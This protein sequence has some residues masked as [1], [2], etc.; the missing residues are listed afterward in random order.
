[1]KVDLKD[2]VW[3]CSVGGI[4]VYSPTGKVIGFIP[5]VEPTNMAFGGSGKQTTLYITA[6]DK[7][8]QLVLPD[9]N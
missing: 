1:M 2:N 3:S 8:Y 7:V 6:S 9:Y 5:I 4:T